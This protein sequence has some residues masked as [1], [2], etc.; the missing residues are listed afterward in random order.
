LLG[1]LE[2]ECEVK[3]DSRRKPIG[4]TGRAS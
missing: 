3:P 2:A 1:R 4:F